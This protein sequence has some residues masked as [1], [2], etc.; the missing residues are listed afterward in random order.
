MTHH[1]DTL[2]KIKLSLS[3]SFH[4]KNSRANQSPGITFGI[5]KKKSGIRFGSRV[6][7]CELWKPNGLAISCKLPSL[8]S[9]GLSVLNKGLHKW[10]I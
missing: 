8:R 6:M 5:G 3:A 4:S 7:E 2:P 1:P 9:L 10:F